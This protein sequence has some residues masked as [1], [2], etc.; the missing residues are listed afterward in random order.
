MC[1]RR[2]RA[3]PAGPCPLAARCLLAAALT[4][5]CGDPVLVSETDA[6]ELPAP[7]AGAI[8]D[9]PAAAT[10]VTYSGLVGYW[11]FDERAGKVAVDSSPSSGAGDL[12][13]GAMFTGGGFPRA[14]FTN[15]G[16]LMLDGVDG[17]VALP[18][19]SL[20]ATDAAKTISFWMSYVTPP[21][22]ARQLLSLHDSASGCALQLGLRDGRLGVWSGGRELVAAIAP[23]SRWHHVVYTFDGT[24]HRLVVDG[25]LIPASTGPS[26]ACPIDQALVGSGPGGME[27]FQGS[28]DDLRIFNRAL[29]EGEIAVL[30]E[31]DEPAQT[32][33]TDG[34]LRAPGG[35]GLG[36]QLASGLVAYWPLDEGT[37]TTTADLS[38]YDNGGTLAGAPVWN[39]GGFPAARFANPFSLRLN[40]NGDQVDLTANRLP[41]TDQSLSVSLWF[42]YT[43]AP[44]TGNRTLLALTSSVDS[45]GIQIGTRG[46]NLAVWTWGGTVLVMRPAPPPG[47]HHLAYVFDGTSHTLQVDGQPPATTRA[48]APAPSCIATEAVLGNQPGGRDYFV[49]VLDDVRVWSPRALTAADVNALLAGQR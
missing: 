13:G 36:G 40:G 47:W 42:N 12:Q 20:P 24:S 14:R 30:A 15:P 43:M 6:G 49:G 16:S 27:S 44:V 33:A 34:G 22:G 17:R 35:G 10:P 11:R 45:C 39:P 5:G 7:D 23:R 41:A 31:G 19:A 8:A 46:T 21:A 25:L 18:V 2:F 4:A 32:P 48:A 29:A 9:A 26:P 38:G 28:L 1:P 37:G 3:L